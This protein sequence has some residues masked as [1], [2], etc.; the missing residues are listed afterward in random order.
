M[1]G[2]FYVKGPDVERGVILKFIVEKNYENQD[3]IWIGAPG[4]VLRKNR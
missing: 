2:K 3:W 1:L 4:E